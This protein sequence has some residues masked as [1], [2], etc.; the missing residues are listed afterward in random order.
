MP[1]EGSFR[2]SLYLTLAIACAAIGYAEASF[3]IEAP[4]VAGIR[5]RSPLLYSTG[6]KPASSC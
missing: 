2:L 1:T 6:W 3:L 4:F 5:D